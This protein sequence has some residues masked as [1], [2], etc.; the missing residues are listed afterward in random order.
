LVSCSCFF[1]CLVARSLCCTTRCRVSTAAE[2]VRRTAQQQ[3]DVERVGE[4]EHACGC[5]QV[6]CGASV[7]HA[8]RPRGTRVSSWQVL[9]VGGGSLVCWEQERPPP[10]CNCSSSSSSSRQRICV[11]V[12]AGLV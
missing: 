8:R 4:R 3:R 1:A 6:R 11:Q 9:H 7:R 10:P 12:Q 5:A 2:R